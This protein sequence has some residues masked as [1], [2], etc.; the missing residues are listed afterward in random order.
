MNMGTNKLMHKLEDFLGLSETKQRKKREKL[1]GIIA[2]LQDKKSRLDKEIVLESE[3]DE[4]S[5]RYHELDKQRKAISR[6]LKKAKQQ[7]SYLDQE[8]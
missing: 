8:P 7:A 6:L 1:E 4:T 5:S 2:K 3:L